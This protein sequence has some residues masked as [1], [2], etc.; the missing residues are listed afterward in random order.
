MISVN[1]M[2]EE[3][4]KG[5]IAKQG[6]VYNKTVPL[7]MAYAA[8]MAGRAVAIEKIESKSRV[9][10]VT[11]SSGKVLFYIPAEAEEKIDV[12]GLRK[13]MEAKIAE[14]QKKSADDLKTMDA[15][16]QK[17]LDKVNK[18]IEDLRAKIG[19]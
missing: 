7:T 15:A 13:D 9:D 18:T 3:Q 8:N 4:A 19:K 1:K 14:I 6:L 2:S 5:E 10:L 12:A 11:D 16:Y 17:K